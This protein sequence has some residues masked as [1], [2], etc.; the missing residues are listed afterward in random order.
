MESVQKAYETFLNEWKENLGHISLDLV[1]KIAMARIR[2][3][4]KSES[5]SLP[6]LIQYQHSVDLK[7]KLTELKENGIKVRNYGRMKV[8]EM[9]NWEEEGGIPGAY[10]PAVLTRNVTV[11]KEFLEKLAKDEDI[12]KVEVLPQKP[13]R[14]LKR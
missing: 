10:F 9:E 14:L 13:P 2:R 12:R 1:E 8:V 11:N 4:P 7:P 6:L 3:Y 5:F